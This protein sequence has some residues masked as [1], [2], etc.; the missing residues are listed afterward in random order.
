MQ[1]A[2]YGERESSSA[3]PKMRSANRPAKTNAAPSYPSPESSAKSRPERCRAC[4]K[5]EWSGKKGQDD[6]GNLM[7]LQHQKWRRGSAYFAEILRSAPFGRRKAAMVRNT[8]KMT[9]RTKVNRHSPRAARQ[10]KG[11][12]TT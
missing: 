11:V 4:S 7:G 8:P 9:A 6:F 2:F 1:A 3:L 10:S 12:L 5:R